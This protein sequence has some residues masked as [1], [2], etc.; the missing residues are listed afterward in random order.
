MALPQHPNLSGLGIPNDK[1]KEMMLVFS[2]GLEEVKTKIMNLEKEFEIQYGYNPIE[3]VQSRLKEYDSIIRK[4]KRK[5]FPLTIASFRENIRDIAGIRITCSF[6]SDLYRIVDMLKNHL[7]L[8]IVENK[9]YIKNPK[10]NGYKSLHLILKLRVSV[11]QRIESVYVEVQL[12]TVT[13][14]IWA[15][16]EQT[17]YYEYSSSNSIPKSLREDLRLAAMAAEQLDSKMEFIRQQ[18]DKLKP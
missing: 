9:D 1:F 4:A 13:M 8:E 6:L 10:P 18:M 11:H 5:E 17:I 7:E 3:K 12:R 14:D 15:N 16:L 2:I